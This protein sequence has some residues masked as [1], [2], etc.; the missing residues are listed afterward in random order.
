MTD[1]TIP[2]LLA[3][4]QR[5][6]DVAGLSADDLRTLAAD[7]RTAIIDTVSKNGGHL[8]PSLGVVELTLAMLS[9]FDPGKDKVVWDVGHQAYAW[10]LLTGRAADF[11][12]LRRR[13]GISGFPKPCESEYDHFG[14]GH[15]STSISAALGMALARDLAGDDHHVVAVIGDGSLT[16]GLAFEGLN[17]AGDMGRRLIVILNDN[18]MSISRNVGAL[19]LFLSRNLSKGWARRVKRDV[20]TA[21]KSI[22]GIG[23]EM[24]A[25]AKRSEHSLKSFFTPGMLFEAFQFNY[26]GPVDG[27]DVKALVR[28]LELA[29]TNDRPVLLHVLTRKG[30]GYTPAE[31]NPAFFHGVGRFEPETGRARKPGDTP[32]LPTYTE[33]FG[34]TLCRLADMDERI[35]AITA[36]MPEGTGTNCFRERHP[37]RFVDVGICEQHAVT[38]AAGLAIQGY[39]PFVAIYSTFL[40]RSYDQIVHDVCIQKLP[41]V[42]CLDR[43]GLVGED[44]PTHHGAFDLSF[45][46]HIP[47][48]SIIAPRD[49]ADLQAAMYTA[50]HLDAPLAIRYPRGVGFGI[51]LAESPSPLPV[52][53]GEVLKEGEGVAVIAVG[54]RVHPS[55]E[56]AERLAEETGRH[57]TVFDARWVKPLPEAQLLDIVARHDALLFVEE[58]ALAGG[59]SSAVLELLADRNALSGKHIRRIGLPDEFVEQ[60]T[61]KELRVSLGLCMDGVGKALKELFAAVGNATAS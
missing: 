14:V 5:P 61:Q 56:A 26:I 19:S 3:R 2:G 20:E 31:A 6:T 18:E 50:L 29:K 41:V 23:D 38:F 33:V 55:L 45:L 51:P 35:V 40:Q 39:R 27:H 24:V 36:A 25:Y 49:E 28:N 34:E 48:M 54:S 22:P 46:R 30:K 60:G 47:H 57:A 15:S 13:H 9:T 59:F 42:L 58:N 52:G 43:A 53:V 12:T 8:A 16:A 7:L 4:I 17:Q 32:V 11:H 1:S 37:D 10:K 21:L 44:G